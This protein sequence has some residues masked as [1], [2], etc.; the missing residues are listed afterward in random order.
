MNTVLDL[1]ERQARSFFM[2]SENYC[3]ISLPP[4]FDFTPMLDY[5]KSKTGNNR[6]LNSILKTDADGNKMLP[7]SYDDVNYT[8]ITNKDGRYAYRPLQ[9]TNPYIYYF[10]VRLITQQANWTELKN[11]FQS[12][13][14]VHIEV[15]STPKVK[16]YT[17]KL[18]RSK[19]DIDAYINLYE[20][21]SVELAL[22][23]RYVFVSDITNCYGSIYTHS[24]AWA[25]HTEAVAK[26]NIGDNTLLGNNI[27]SFIQW[28][29][30]NQT[31]GM[32][33]GST[34]FDFIAEIV[35]GYADRL[36]ADDLAQQQ[37]DD[38]NVLRYR[39]DYRIFCNNKE[40]LEKI[41]YTLQKVL[42][43]LNMRLNSNKTFISDD[44]ISA[45]YKS[46]K[47]AYITS[48]SIKFRNKSLYTTVQKELLY[49][50][51]F[52]KQY[53]N[54][55]TAQGMLAD[56]QVRIISEKPVDENWISII[57]I[58]VDIAAD[59]PKLYSS[60]ISLM[61]LA[62]SNITTK[63]QQEDVVRKVIAKLD[64]LPNK[65][66]FQLWM[67]RI[68]TTILPAGIHYEEQL[69]DIVDNNAGVKLWN[70]DWVDDLY[71][72]NMPIYNV[73]NQAMLMACK[74]I[75]GLDEYS[76]FVY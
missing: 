15:A 50:R 4:Y 66:I 21:R 70:I 7:S 41:S 54:S 65:G 36:L 31:N 61:S 18:R 10:L 56:L 12:F 32:P 16:D 34:L 69:C 11:L 37:I 52:C 53:P 38:Y 58:L 2:E 75:I 9:L 27:D 20:Q 42:L 28:M 55:G 8:M 76:P 63:A 74:P 44:V 68:T 47:Y 43:H 71:K 64:Y 45:S 51:Q 35:L 72:A 48:S 26:A 40:T 73:V 1:N 24:I 49:I 59:N 62:I 13:Q 46:D 39:D 67:Q 5:V 30:Y 19:Y 57:S 3:N 25:V 17:E 22:S 33:Q 60:I 14:D 29:Q 23:Y 6:T